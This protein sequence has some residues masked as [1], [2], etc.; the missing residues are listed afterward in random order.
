M[1]K[2]YC[3]MKKPYRF[4]N[5]LSYTATLLG[6]FGLAA[7]FFYFSNNLNIKTL[8]GRVDPALPPLQ[9]NGWI[10]WWDEG[11]ALKSLQ[12]SSRK[13]TSVSP[14]WYKIDTEG[15]L[16]IIPHSLGRSEIKTVPAI[17]NDFD[18]KRVS[19]I[20]NNSDISQKYYEELANLAVSNE[21]QGFDIDWEEINPEDQQSF[22][23][24]IQKLA[25]F[26]HTYN[27]VLTVSVHPQTGEVSDRDVAKGYNLAEL[28]KSAD[29]LKI[30]A[31][32]IHNQNSEPGAIIPFSDLI[33]ILEYT[34]KVVPS[35]KI[36]LGIPTY[37][38]DWESGSKNAEVVSFKEA[39]DK[40]KKYNGNIHRDVESGS[41]VGEYV[42]GGKNHSIWFED[43]ETINKI[44]DKAKSFGVYQFSFWRIGAEDPE[45]WDKLIN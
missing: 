40:I 25:D 7:A 3:P 1:A 18:P 41:L 30:M 43:S 5:H 35:E 42:L 31:Y 6:L 2:N 44:I 11:N 24:F 32:D 39:S 29:A 27:L 36:I 10:A 17:T 4:L 26:L 15:K 21:Y 9:F 14:V 28:S 23:L 38:Y 37:G 19:K 16:Q 20:I 8:L 22:G 45:M 13:L 33:K 34:S 12:A